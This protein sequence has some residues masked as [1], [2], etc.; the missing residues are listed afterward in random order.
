MTY[1]WKVPIFT[2]PAQQAGEE[3]ERIGQKCGAL[4]PENVVH[5]SRDCNAVLHGCFEWNDAKAAELYRVAQAS[6]II[7]T[8]VVDVKETDDSFPVRVRAF[9]AVDGEYQ[10]VRKVVTDSSIYEKVLEEAKAE[11]S[12]FQNKYS[13]LE[14]LHGVCSEI[15][16][17]LTP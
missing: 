2:I 1:K 8:I 15:D 5:E 3:L 6:K 9:F 4:T 16:K 13:A 11:L 10:S 14:A 7:R 12:A 17:L